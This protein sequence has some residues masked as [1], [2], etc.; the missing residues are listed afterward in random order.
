MSSVQR[1]GIPG[2]VSFDYCDL[3][4]TAPEAVKNFGGAGDQIKKVL[5]MMGIEMPIVNLP[6]FEQIK[7]LLSPAL[8]VSWVDADGVYSKSI[9]P[10]PL[11]SCLLGDPQQSMTALGAVTATTAIVIPSLQRARA[12]ARQVQTAS[13][14]R[15]ILLALMNYATSHHGTLP[16]DLGTL[17]Q[18]GQIKTPA[19]FTLFLEVGSKTKVPPELA[20][21][22]R[23]QQAAWVNENCV[24]TFLL[25]GRKISDINAPSQT[26]ALVPKDAD[27]ATARVNVGFADGHVEMCKPE[28]AQHFLHPDEAPENP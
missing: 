11:S 18:D 23:D 7:P 28:R 17:V 8:S 5:G 27:H 9:S 21:S 1:L 14:Q 20:N 22:T 3:P 2:F 24:Y 15:Q 26:A 6:A 19:A 25:A 12:A 16:P 10:F 4:R 13:N